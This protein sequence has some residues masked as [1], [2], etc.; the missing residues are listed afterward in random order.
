M[1]PMILIVCYLTLFGLT[2]CKTNTVNKKVDLS[3]VKVDYKSIRFD[4][5][6]YAC[7]TN[8]LAMEV[9]AL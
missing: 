6:L 8:K 7:D 1:M 3:A 5:E 2:A 9:N 4:K